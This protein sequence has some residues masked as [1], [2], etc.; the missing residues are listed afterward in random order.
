MGIQQLTSLRLAELTL[1]QLGPATLTSLKDTLTAP[2]TPTHR[3]PPN[4]MPVWST[5]D[6]TQLPIAH[7]NPDLPVSIREHWGDWAE[8]VCENNWTGWVDSRHLIPGP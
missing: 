1:A 3:A 7:L 5:P 6:T 2:W 8:I 4:G